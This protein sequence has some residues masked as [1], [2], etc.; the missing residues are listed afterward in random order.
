MKTYIRAAV[1]ILLFLLGAAVIILTSAA[2]VMILWNEIVPELL[3]LPQIT[4]R[5]AL[6]L[7]LLCCI[8]FGRFSYNRPQKPDW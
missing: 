3:S 7:Y 5:K 4:Y 1:I 2:L 8:L 6:T